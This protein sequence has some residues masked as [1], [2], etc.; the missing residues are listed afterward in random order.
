MFRCFIRHA[1]LAWLAFFVGAGILNLLTPADT[2]HS[3]LAG[4]LAAWLSSLVCRA[5]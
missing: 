3:A 5:S 4:S 1:A 2:L